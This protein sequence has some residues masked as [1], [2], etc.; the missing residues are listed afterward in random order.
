[1]NDPADI[2]E[3]TEAVHKVARIQSILNSARGPQALNCAD[4]GSEIPEIRRLALA[5]L[6]VTR[7]VFCQELVERNRRNRM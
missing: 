2:C 1:M 6:A 5:G 3:E 4:C 7:C